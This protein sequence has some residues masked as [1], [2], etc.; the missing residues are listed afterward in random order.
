MKIHKLEALNLE[1]TDPHEVFTKAVVIGSLAMMLA[2]LA[3][4]RKEEGAGLDLTADHT[5]IVIPLGG[6]TRSQA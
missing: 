2:E 1:T 4:K 3:A 6:K 5:G